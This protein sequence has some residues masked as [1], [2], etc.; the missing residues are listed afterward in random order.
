MQAWQPASATRRT[1][2]A[3][4]APPGWSS[5]GLRFGGTLALTQGAAVEADAVVAWAPVARGS[6]TSASCSCSACRCP[7][8]RARPSGPAS[9]RRAPSSRRRHWPSWGRSTCE[10]CRI[11]RPRRVLVV[12]RDDKPASTPLLDRLRDTRGRA[13]PRRACGHRTCSSTTPPS[14]PWCPRTSSTRSAAWVGPVRSSGRDGGS[15]AGRAGPRRRSPGRAE[16]SKKRSWNSGAGPGRHPHPAA[17]RRLRG[18]PW[19]G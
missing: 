15:R 9:C 3:A 2:C 4:G 10:R 11:A 17:V 19:S 1:P 8:R 18:A 13:G 6:A 5:S 12:D 7:R 14:T 16:P